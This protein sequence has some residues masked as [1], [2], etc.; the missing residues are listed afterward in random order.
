[1]DTTIISSHLYESGSTTVLERISMGQKIITHS[2]KV[3][4]YISQK[5]V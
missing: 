2:H 5:L 4:S 3:N 1:M